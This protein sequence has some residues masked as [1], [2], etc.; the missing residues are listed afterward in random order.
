VVLR[1]YLELSE[2]EAAQAMGVTRGTVKS[3]THRGL[4][5]VAR[6]IREES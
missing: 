3:A 2:A 1:Y 4:A 5:A 6:I